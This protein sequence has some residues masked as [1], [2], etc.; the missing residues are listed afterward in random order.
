MEEVQRPRRKGKVIRW[1]TRILALIIL[2]PLAILLI[3]NYAGWMR[4]RKTDREIYAVLGPYVAKVDIDTTHIRGRTIA[5]I[6]ASGDETPKNTAVILVHGSPGSIDIALPYMSDTALL[7][8]ADIIAY[9][10]PGFGNSGYG[11]SL[12][13][14]LRQADVLNTLMD[15][16]GYTSYYLLGQNYGSAVS[17]RAA[18]QRTGKLKGLCLISA[19]V[20]PGLQPHTPVWR[21]WVDLPILRGIIPA[22]MRVSN[23]ELMSYYYDLSM[24]E[25]DW[26][27]LTMPVALLHGD[28][29]PL[30]P[31]DNLGFSLQKLVSADTVYSRVFP[32]ESQFVFWTRKAEVV[33]ELMT[34]MDFVQRNN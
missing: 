12:P 10:R 31:I 22:T 17:A 5:W 34:L 13:S 16:L 27:R 7:A 32:G 2:L 19:S 20:D 11:T 24:M 14:L 4:M 23:E 1:S 25:D 33:G 28:E 8:R 26:D 9:D 18:M 15:S 6:R 30:S 29:D 3:A 21:K